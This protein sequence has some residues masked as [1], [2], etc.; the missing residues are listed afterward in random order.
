MGNEG[1]AVAQCCIEFTQLRKIVG[2]RKVGHPPRTFAKDP[3][4]RT[5]VEE[6]HAAARGAQRFDRE[7]GRL[8]G[9]GFGLRVP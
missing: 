6:L 2:N 3:H 4:D 9:V 5:D 1:F 8:G 7:T